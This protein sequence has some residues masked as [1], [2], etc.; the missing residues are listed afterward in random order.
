MC[1][2]CSRDSMA[3]HRLIVFCGCVKYLCT[4]RQS[5]CAGAFLLSHFDSISMG[6]GTIETN[7]NKKKIDDLTAY[8]QSLSTVYE[9]LRRIAEIATATAHWELMKSKRCY[10]GVI[11]L[12]LYK[13]WHHDIANRAREMKNVL[14][15][16]YLSIDFRAECYLGH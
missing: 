6:D 8:Q 13:Y 1:L 5:W 10:V 3:C 7:D 11:I 14:C 15:C 2:C 12:Y 4:V 16:T 9:I